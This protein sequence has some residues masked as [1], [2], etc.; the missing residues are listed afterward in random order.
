MNHT[1]GA[2]ASLSNPGRPSMDDILS[3]PSMDQLQRDSQSR[4]LLA[5]IN[6][7]S[8]ALPPDV[9]SSASSTASAPSGQVAAAPAPAAGESIHVAVDPH[10]PANHHGVSLNMNSSGHPTSSN[11]GASTPLPPVATDSKST[12]TLKTKGSL[13]KMAKTRSDYDLISI[14]HRGKLVENPTNKEKPKVHINMD[15]EVLCEFLIFS[16]L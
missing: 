15:V 14:K 1:P 13:T 4:K 12:H 7:T 16:K 3:K 11:S 10:R 6:I 9:T 5:G 8:S 2:G